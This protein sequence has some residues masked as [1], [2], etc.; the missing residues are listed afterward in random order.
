[1]TQ[2]REQDV[3]QEPAGIIISPGVRGEVTPRF[4]AYVWAQDDDPVPTEPTGQRAA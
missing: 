3:E 1:M 4:R 2:I